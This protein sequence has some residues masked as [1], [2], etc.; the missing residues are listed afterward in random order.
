MSLLDHAIV[1]FNTYLKEEETELTKDDIVEALK[2]YQKN[3]TKGKSPKYA[4]N[5]TFLCDILIYLTHE[6]MYIDNVYE[7]ENLPTEEMMPVLKFINTGEPI[8]IMKDVMYD[9]AY[10]VW[11]AFIEKMI[12]NAEKEESDKAT[13]TENEWE[14]LYGI[15]PIEEGSEILL[16]TY[17][18]GP[19]GGYVLKGE[20]HQDNG[21]YLFPDGYVVYKAHRNWGIPW[22]LS[23]L[24]GKKIYYKQKDG[25][26]EEICVVDTDVVI[27]NDDADVFLCEF[28]VEL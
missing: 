26:E 19:E 17:G 16:Q 6:S 20:H 24:S 18:G 22:Q 21:Y 11:M 13:D 4:F 27:N 12:I 25:E 1:A 3:L 8:E 15:M 9:S 2:E 28:G 23:L 10:C 14:T 7:W 5:F